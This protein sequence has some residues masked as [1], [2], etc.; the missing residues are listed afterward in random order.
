MTK[1]KR[2]GRQKQAAPETT[3]AADDA[4]AV[5]RSRITGHQKIRAGD[6]KGHP[7]N[8]RLHD[9]AQLTA[10]RDGMKE[11]GPLVPIL[12]AR[13]GDGFLIIDGHARV[14]SAHPDDALDVAIVDIDDKEAEFALAVLDSSSAQAGTDVRRVEQLLQEVDVASVGVHAVLGQ[15][16]DEVMKA[17]KAIEDAAAA[18]EPDEDE[19]GGGEGPAGPAAPKA[20]KLKR[21]PA[22]MVRVSSELD[23][24][25]VE[26]AVSTVPGCTCKKVTA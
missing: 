5:L 10:I 14:Q 12:A 6:L 3:P 22:L 1:P 20:K 17:V 11:F 25:F 13:R 15:L 18:P 21:P 23:Y 19:G 9:N 4:A 16:E 8:Y 7:L 2:Q 24:E 26:L